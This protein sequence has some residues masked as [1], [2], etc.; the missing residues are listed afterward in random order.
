VAHGSNI[1]D[2]GLVGYTWVVMHVAFGL[3]T[4]NQNACYIEEDSTR[5]RRVRTLELPAS[6]W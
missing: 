4:A 5:S 1:L 6:G 3:H 2:L